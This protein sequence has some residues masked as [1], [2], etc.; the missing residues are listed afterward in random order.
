MQ[1]ESCSFPGVR[2]TVNILIAVERITIITKKPMCG[3]RNVTLSLNSVEDL[4]IECA[5][6]SYTF[7]VQISVYMNLKLQPDFESA[8]QE[9]LGHI[10]S[11][12][13]NLAGS[14]DS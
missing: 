2:V 6:W 9:A 3:S 10:C 14:V 12:P 11:L 8:S 4:N 7:A 13:I 1:E 5:D